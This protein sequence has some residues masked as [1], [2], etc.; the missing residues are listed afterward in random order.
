MALPDLW[1]TSRYRSR[2]AVSKC[3]TR[4]DFL[5]IPLSVAPN[6]S[7]QGSLNMI[8]L[9]IFDSLAL[10]TKLESVAISFAEKLLF[11]YRNKLEHSATT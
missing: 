1:L 5:A 4:F 6:L 9:L 10:K 7:V 11:V 3:V 8:W 2:S